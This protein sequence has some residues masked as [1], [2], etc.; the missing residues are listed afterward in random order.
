MKRLSV[1]KIGG[2]VIDNPAALEKFLDDFAALPAPKLLVHGGGKI[3]TSVAGALGIESRMIE[4]RRVTSPEML[5]VAVMVYAGLV[6]KRVVAGL[7]RRGCD[8]A[9][10]CGADGKAVTATKRPP[11]S[12]G[13]QTVDYGMV[14]DV[15]GVDCG[16]ISSLLEKGVTPVFCAISYS[17]ADGLLN[18]NADTIAT[19]VAVAMSS[20][21][22]TRLLF[23]FEKEGVLRDVDDPSSVITEIT[24]STFEGL[25]AEG[26][27]HSGMVPKISNALRAVGRGVGSVGIKNSARL[28]EKAGTDILPEK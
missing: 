25:R 6:N 23:C 15:V 17:E 27:V 22:D 21:Y 2:N 13:G 4:G 26:A 9:G 10:L 14:G 8:A 3:A 19:E 12:V 11:V 1:V 7:Q 24:A 18:T 16:F 20:A 5:D 28:L